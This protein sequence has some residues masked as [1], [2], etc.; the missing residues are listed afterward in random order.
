MRGRKHTEESKKKMSENNHTPTGELNPLYGKKRKEED[1]KSSVENHPYYKGENN[2][3]W[4]MKYSEET[5]RKMSENHADYS[6][7]NHPLFGKS[8][9]EETRKKIS[10]GNIGKF[11]TEET[12][13][14]MSKSRMF[15]KQKG[16]SSNFIGVCFAKS[17]GYWMAT[18]RYNKKTISMGTFKTEMEAV[19]AYNE[20]AI[21]LYGLDAKL[22]IIFE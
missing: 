16:A 20:K 4:G 21:E 18:I 17:T 1:V 10:E 5:R 15:K 19:F 12:K 7:E 22:N 6:G 14:E 11:H 2:P 8:P 3:R 9:S 13:E